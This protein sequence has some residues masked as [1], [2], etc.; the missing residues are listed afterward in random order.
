MS[1]AI[2]PTTSKYA[3]NQLAR[4]M[5]A[6]DADSMYW[7]AR[8]VERAENLARILDV[9][10]IFANDS[11]D[12][13]SWRSVLHLNSDEERFLKRHEVAGDLAMFAADLGLPSW[14]LS[15]KRAKIGENAHVLNIRRGRYGA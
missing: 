4:P 7:M 8:Y 12:P 6:R 10:Q 9:Q 14:V 15:L 1:E 5:L 13:E 11:R 3:F 2:V